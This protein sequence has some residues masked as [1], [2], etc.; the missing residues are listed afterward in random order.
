MSKQLFFDE[1]FSERP[2]ND[3]LDYLTKLCGSQNEALDLMQKERNDWME[4]CKVQE[5][6]LQNAEAAFNN[7]KD[8]VNNLVTKSNADNQENGQ[9]IHQLERMVGELGGHIN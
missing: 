5:R 3:Q 9:R 4:K 8:I 7:Q 1:K 6:S 2:I